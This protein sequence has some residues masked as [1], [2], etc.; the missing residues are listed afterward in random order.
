M[1][2]GWGHELERRR[3]G[4][5]DWVIFRDASKN[6]EYLRSMSEM[7]SG[8]SWE[9]C[10]FEYHVFTELYAVE[11]TAELPYAALAADLG[12]RGVPSVD[13]ALKRLMFRPVHQPLRAALGKGHLD[14]LA[15][16]WD[17]ATGEP[18]EQAMRALE[19]RIEHVADG[20]AYMRRDMK[21]ETT[22]GQASEASAESAAS[23][24]SPEL[25][26]VLKPLR[27]RYGAIL[28]RANAKPSD[29]KAVH[30]RGEQATARS[31]TT[32]PGAAPAEDAAKQ[33]DAL[34]PL[35]T[36]LLLAWAQ[37]DAVL[38]LF[39]QVEPRASRAH[40]IER[41]ELALP[42]VEAFGEELSAY[43]AE[44]RT[45]LVLL[46]VTL[47]SAPLRE[48]LRA[49]FADAR[50]RTF[51]GIHEA[52]GVLWLAKERFELLARVVADRE[53]ALGHASVAMADRQV[54]DAARLASAEGYRAARVEQAL[55]GSIGLAPPSASPPRSS[56]EEPATPRSSS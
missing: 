15:A 49:S 43:D 36:P 1:G 2:H 9:L 7:Q 11:A 50:A 29:A 22:F 40:L 8:L 38:D 31:A 21:V 39:A 12:A 41:Y 54:D 4:Q 25:E 13:K 10:A 33:V 34:Q 32:E 26:A 47:P 20:L 56:S 45:A 27:D 6:L 19:E 53:V 48:V 18:T 52:N 23:A 16:G 5:G 30:L 55:A 44:E 24:R 3:D 46:T 51:L 14:Y 37:V 35:D 28:A 42:I 17:D